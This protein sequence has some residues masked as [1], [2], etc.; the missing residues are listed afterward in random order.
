LNL[1]DVAGHKQTKPE[2]DKFELDWERPRLHWRRDQRHFAYEKIDR[3]HQRFRVIA[4]D[5][6][7][8]Q[9]RNLID[10]RTETFIWTAHTENLG[11]SIVTWLDKSDDFIY[12]SERDGWRHLYFVDGVTGEIRNQITKGEWV[13]RGIDRVDEDAKRSGSMP[14]AGTRIRTRTSSITT[15]SISTGRTS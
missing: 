8:G 3:G 1:F 9:A 2:V 13:V 15:E 14:A 5:S 7:T 11:L 10:E 6:H 12:A 4:V